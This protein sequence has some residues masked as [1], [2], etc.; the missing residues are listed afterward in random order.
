MGRYSLSQIEPS[1]A[2]FN[3]LTPLGSL[4]QCYWSRAV[5]STNNTAQGFPRGVKV[6][7]KPSWEGSILYID[8]YMKCLHSINQVCE[9]LHDEWDTQNSPL[10]FPL[11]DRS[12]TYPVRLRNGSRPSEGR[13]EVLVN[14]HWGTICDYSWDSY[15]AGVVCR[16]LG[17]SGNSL[18]HI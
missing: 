7:L 1:H 9:Y 3:P 14:G 12:I 13:V 5:P 17:Y 15:D 18:F 8:L 16:Q 10:C 4:G 11:T 6:R 2:G